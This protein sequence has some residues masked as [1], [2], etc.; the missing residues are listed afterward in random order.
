MACMCAMF[1]YGNFI[2]SV[3]DMAASYS[4]EACVWRSQKDHWSLL[5]MIVLATDFGL[6]GPYTGQMKAAILAQAPNVPVIDLFADLP[7]G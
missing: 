3:V 5:S 2:N 7:A 6:H 4:Y 1:M